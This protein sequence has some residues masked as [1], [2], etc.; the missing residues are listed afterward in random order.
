MGNSEAASK[1]GAQTPDALS[2]LADPRRA[3]GPTRFRVEWDDASVGG[4]R[5]S[6][7]RWGL[8]AVI[9][10]LSS[11]AV[12][13]VAILPEERRILARAGLP[14]AAAPGLVLRP[15]LARAF[16]RLVRAFATLPPL[17]SVGS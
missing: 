13:I 7:E 15:A 12:D 17:P 6:C 10:S 3:R 4:R 14:P 16:R 9:K 8:A 5:S 11:S 2:N 1:H